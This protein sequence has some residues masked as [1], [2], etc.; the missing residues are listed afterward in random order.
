[1]PDNTRVEWVDIAKAFAIILVVIYHTTV[2]GVP[3]GVVS[4]E[5]LGIAAKFEAF[6]MP[7]FFFA[8]GL[9][10]ES[11]IKRPWKKIW[12]TRIAL[13]VWAFL[14]WTVLRFIYFLLVPMETRP[15]ETSLKW[16]L[17]APIWPVTGLWFLHALAYFFVLTKLIVKV[18]LAVKLSAAAVVSMVFFSWGIGNISYDGMARY[19]LF[20]LG[21]AYLREFTLE[22]NKTPRW[23]LAL[24]CVVL[25]GLTVQ[26]L[27]ATG[28]FGTFGTRTLLGVFAVITGCLVARV[29]EETGVRSLFVFI[30]KNTLPIYVTHIILIAALSTALGALTAGGL[31]EAVK[32]AVPVL[33]PIAVVSLALLAASLA[34]RS[35]V[36]TYLFDVP[37]WFVQLRLPGRATLARPVR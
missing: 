29:V 33:G 11:V 28:M 4:A 35:R 15:G 5:W 36:S 9:F 25:F 31:P 13:L 12:S 8:A 26:A 16:L 7:V 17:L 34:K 23:P 24:A 27:V 30:G 22:R 18:P 21:G 6:R 3:V 2:I 14:L 1:M 32:H 37:D 19:Y 10:A 20:F